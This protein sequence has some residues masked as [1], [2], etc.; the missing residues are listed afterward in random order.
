M[1]AKMLSR[2]FILGLWAST[3]LAPAL[4]DPPVRKPIPTTVVPKRQPDPP[5]AAVPAPVPV[6]VAKKPPPAP[7]RV[8][9][10][11]WEDVPMETVV[12]PSRQYFSTGF[13]VDAYCVPTITLSPLMS[14]VPGS[15]IQTT[16]Q[17]LVCH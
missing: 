15:V 16:G 17:N 14:T 2:G 13:V 6:P 1:K 12:T 3:M 10:C 8:Q 9:T 7:P 4:A 11:R 5:A